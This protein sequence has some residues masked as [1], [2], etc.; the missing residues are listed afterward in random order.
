MDVFEA[1]KNRRSVRQYKDTPV[2]E[3]VLNKVLEA[4]RWAPSWANTQCTRYV[5]IKDA[6]TKA[7][8]AETVN[9]GNPSTEAL[10]NAPI[11]IVACAELKRSGFYKGEVSTDR[12]EWFMFDVGIAME[13]LALAA[14]ALG[15]GTVHVGFIPDS[16]KVE[17]IIGTPEGVVAVEMTPLGYPSAD[18]KAPPR[19]E[20]SDIVFYEKYGKH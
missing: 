10:K 3:E 5:V 20:L 14:H 11:V 8:L 13:H 9:K 1:I 6:A 7:R 12:G 16:K 2:S 4:A 18:A 15:L 19:K 17:E